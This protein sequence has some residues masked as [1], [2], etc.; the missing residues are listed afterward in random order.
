MAEC[1]HKKHA[2][3]DRAGR[4][5]AIGS[6]PN[7]VRA[8]DPTMPPD[9][10]NADVP[11][12]TVPAKTV[13][14]TA[15]QPVRLADYA[16]YPWDVSSVDLIFDL[17]PTNTRVT[18][19][20]VAVRK[21]D[22]DPDC[23]LV[24][25]GEDL[26]LDTIAVDGQP[27][28]PAAYT[29]NGSTLTIQSPPDALTVDIVTRVNPQANT[30]LS[31]LY[32]SGGMLCTQCEAEGFRR[33]TYFPDRPDVLARY[34]VT[35]VA[36]RAAFPVLLSNGN[37]VDAGES[38]GGRHWA[39][40]DDPWPKPAYLFALVA[41]DLKPVTDA[42]TTRSGRAVDL[43]IW[44]R[45]PD[46]DQCGHAM[47]ALKSAMA[48][49]ERVYGLEYDLGVFNIVAVSDFN[50]GAMENKG[51]N[52]F[53]SA[54]LL[55]R[56]D[57]AT[58]SDYQRIESVVA[59]EY[60]HNWT[61]N[62][63]T[64]RDWFQLSLKE[65]L[66]VF[67]DQEFSADTGSR[68]VKRIQDVRRL[69]ASQFPEDAGPMAHPVLPESYIEINN[70]Y[71]PTVYEKGAEVIRMLHRIIGPDAF[72]RGM[73]LY[74]ARHDGQAVTC[75]DFVAA[76][77]TASGADLG[78]FRT[79]YQQAGTPEVSVADHYDP[80]SRRYTVTVNQRTGPTP[81]QPVKQALHIPIVLGLVGSDGRD[82]PA[83]LMAGEGTAGPD[84]WLL[85]LRHDRQQFVFAGVAERPVPSVLRGFCAPVKVKPASVERLTVLCA[86][87]CD[88]VARWDAG[89]ELATR[90]ILDLVSDHQAGR[91]LSAPASF[92]DAVGQTLADQRL[93]D[94]LV[95]EMLRLPGLDDV[96]DAMIR[97]DFGAID[98]A[99]S[100]VSRALATALA[101][102][103]TER[104]HG[105]ADA[106]PFSADAAAVGRRALRGVCL[107]LLA[108]APDQAG[109][110]LAAGLADDAPTMTE[111][112]AALAVLNDHAGPVRE[113]ALAAFLD[114]W[115]G[116][117]LVVDKWFRLHATSRLEDTLD[118][119]VGLTQH[120]LF[121]RRVPNRL[122]ALVGSFAYAN[123]L[124]FHRADGA[125]YAFL[126]DQVIAT[127]AINPQIAARLV[128]PLGRW[129]RHD[130]GRQ[131]HMQA[132]L[133][134]ILDTKPLSS[135][136]YEIARKSLD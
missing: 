67:R 121:T 99:R 11:A 68:A 134:R 120:P 92:V 98:A 15:P 39:K 85:H 18:M 28:D 128:A 105:L 136:V 21:P 20:L 114:A 7:P 74:F 116:Q 129:R 32:L 119:V 124:R 100:A 37:P 75:E 12:R 6:S 26:V 82:L 50:M 130:P 1:G 17:H 63:V 115:R 4:P 22:A 34:T 48:W 78:Q 55:A 111:R 89:R 69:R 30:E 41:G 118:R 10:P 40:W 101:P 70:F 108:Y 47:S 109:V 51:L 38:L 95:A 43:A 31:G 62:R 80:E 23:A 49:D 3:G 64:C 72:R 44:V 57:T 91:P 126:A 60:F 52:I 45:E 58:D 133:S 135:D 8:K 84:G 117:P 83:E 107:D 93:D 14:D 131:A 103:L 77:E 65:G 5:G 33:I 97:V 87:D 16:P 35:L 42:F 19:R 125:G 88:P 71:T 94:A 104:F 106:G 56:P 79:W 27:L 36:D 24:L 9:H 61:G 76:M 2:A 127:D 122:R 96:A 46:L 66:T 53:N 132:A 90:V 73:D 54:L 112:L 86:R 13:P 29:T 59:H 123:P 113:A 81:G 102:A 25:D 110:T